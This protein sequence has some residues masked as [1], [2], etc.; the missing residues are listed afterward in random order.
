MIK[1]A[2][3]AIL[4][5]FPEADFSLIAIATSQGGLKAISEILSVLPADFPAAITLVQ[6]LS[7][8]YPSYMAEILARRTALRVKPAEDG[9]RLRPGTVY[10]PIPNKHLLIKADRTICLSDEPKMNFV[11]PAATKMFASVAASFK[12]RAIAVVLTGKLSDGALGVVAIK[13]QGG[14]VIAQDEASCEYFSMPEAAIATGKVDL[15]LPL[16]AIAGTLLELVI[17]NKVL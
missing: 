12:T 13:K 6:H 4:S 16:S 14:L 15:I 11:R 8:D 7:A 5:D 9:E 3:P 10:T 17:A 1:Q 2:R